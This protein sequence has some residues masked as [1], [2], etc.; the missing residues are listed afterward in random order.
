MI[1]HF[2]S[3]CHKL[4][5]RR[6]HVIYKNAFLFQEGKK[7][8]IFKKMS[9]GIKESK[10][11]FYFLLKLSARNP[12]GSI[13][14]QYLENK[15]IHP[16]CWGGAGKNKKNALIFFLFLPLFEAGGNCSYLY[17]AFYFIYSKDLFLFYS[18]RNI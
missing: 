6:I 14:S 10:K 8:L 4:D 1:P 17:M 11:Y 2:T 5:H 13:K 18:I 9:L 12:T 15:F 3:I 16:H 7:N